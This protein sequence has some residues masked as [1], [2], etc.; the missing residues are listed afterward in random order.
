MNATDKAVG[1]P[2][3]RYDPADP[4]NIEKMSALDLCIVSQELFPY[5]DKLEIDKSKRSTPFRLVAQNS[6]VYTDHFTL[7]L[8]FKDIP[9]AVHKTL[10]RTGNVRWNTNKPGGWD[11]FISLTTSNEALEQIANTS[12]DDSNVI[13]N[14]I[15]KEMERI[16]YMSFGKVKFC[17]IPRISKE[18]ASL[19]TEKATMGD[20]STDDLDFR[21][22]A[23]VL[24]QQREQFEA[25]IA[26][27][28]NLKTKNGSA[29][30]V[31]S[32]RGNVIG[33]K[34]ASTDA[35]AI[36]DPSSGKLV[37]S[38]DDIKRVSLNYCQNLLTNREPKHSFIEDINMKA[39]IHEVRYAE[40]L[41]HDYNELS[42]E[43]FLNSLTILGSRYGSK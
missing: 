12:L 24:Q 10:K 17:G 22:N 39:I 20:A 32:L 36:S 34:K 4:E 6:R 43:Q 5:I 21:I 19:M 9:Q 14:R 16:K 2:F 28:K 38:E 7:L 23:L 27:L 37:F 41:E 30:A 1:G 11:K 3:T 29:A 18:I 40:V 15:H 31:F 13:M 8:T 33:Q 26:G 42:Y 35:V 25:D